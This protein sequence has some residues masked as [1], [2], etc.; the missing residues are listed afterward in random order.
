ML[1]NGLLPFGGQASVEG[2]LEGVERG[3][4]AVGPASLVGAG[5]VQAYDRQVDTLECGLFLG[6]M[7]SGVDRSAV[8]ARVD[9]RALSVTLRP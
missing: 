4:P 1:G 3:D 7:S 9:S 8:P 5:G 6:E 2:D